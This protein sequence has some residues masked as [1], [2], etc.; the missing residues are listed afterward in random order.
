MSAETKQ[1]FDEAL[2]AHLTDETDGGTLTGYVMQAQYTSVELMDEN[3]SGYLRLTGE[4]QPF[5]TTLG[6]THFLAK[7]MDESV[8]DTM[9]LNDDDA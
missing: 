9:N 4:R 8:M 2:A 6:L 3:A 5:T 7:Q 1:A